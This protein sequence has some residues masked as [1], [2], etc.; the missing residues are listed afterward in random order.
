MERAHLV[1][2]RAEAQRVGKDDE[3]TQCLRQPVGDA[4]G[5]VVAHVI[6]AVGTVFGPRFLEEQGAQPQPATGTIE[7]GVLERSNSNVVEE[8]VQLIN[9]YRIYEAGSKAVTTQDGMLDKSVN[10]VGRL[11]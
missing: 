11:G 9:N 7:Q 1:T 3:L 8:M 5:A 10:D 2:E 6:V 4:R